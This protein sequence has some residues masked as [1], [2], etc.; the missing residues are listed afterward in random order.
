MSNIKLIIAE[1]EEVYTKLQSQYSAGQATLNKIEVELIMIRGELRVL[2]TLLQ[3]DKNEV[4]KMKVHGAKKGV[5]NG[6][7]E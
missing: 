4:T 6:Q 3:E 7:K 5:E 1:K 2:N